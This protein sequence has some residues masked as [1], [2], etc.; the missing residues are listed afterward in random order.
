MTAVAELAVRTTLREAYSDGSPQFR[1]K[2]E[3]AQAQPQPQ[4]DEPT[5]RQEQSNCS[6]CER[7]QLYYFVPQPGASLGI[8]KHTYSQYRVSILGAASSADGA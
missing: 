6:V 3:G 4:H 2:F 8:D 7:S 5:L 1:P